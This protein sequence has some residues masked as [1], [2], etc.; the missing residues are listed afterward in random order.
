MERR[1][2]ERGPRSTRPMTR[3]GDVPT[4]GSERSLGDL[5]RE[6]ADETRMLVRQE[7]QLAKVEVR[8]IAREA[9]RNMGMAA[10]GGFVAYAGFVVLVV[11]LAFLLAN[12][13]PVWLSFSL[14]GLVVLLVGYALFRS[15]QH[16]LQETDFRLE[17]TTESLQ[18]DKQWAKQ[19]AQD[20]RN[21]PSRLGASR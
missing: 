7:F 20:V 11:G 2:E 1:E 14:V 10:A 6:L 8:E 15:G 19:E 13:M 3:R 4:T 16:G 18:E 12:V 9:S 5:F 17:R 21:D